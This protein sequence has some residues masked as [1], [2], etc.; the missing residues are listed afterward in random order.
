M[1]NDSSTSNAIFVDYLVPYD[2][3]EFKDQ[4]FLYDPDVVA[5]EVVTGGNNAVNLAPP[6]APPPKLP[7]GALIS[8]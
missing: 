2:R 7:G 6:N 1:T 8:Q 3:F 4:W 5:E